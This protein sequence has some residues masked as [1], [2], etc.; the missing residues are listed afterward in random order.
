MK[1]T[2]IGWRKFAGFLIACFFV[3]FDKISDQVWLIAFGI[4]VGGNVA[5]KFI[6]GGKK[7]A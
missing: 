5:A 6:G 1:I 2:P 3:W 7:D 4:F